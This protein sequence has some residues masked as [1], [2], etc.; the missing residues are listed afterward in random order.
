MLSSSVR[1]Q[2]N[3]PH[4]YG[5]KSGNS[6]AIRSWTGCVTSAGPIPSLPHWSAASRFFL[7]TKSSNRRR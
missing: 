5:S 4:G 6:R 2:S 3:R 7:A 1:T